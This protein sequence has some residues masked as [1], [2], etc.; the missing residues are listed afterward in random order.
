MRIAGRQANVS[1]VLA[2]PQVD[3]C[4]QLAPMSAAQELLK[5]S[6]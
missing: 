1:A 6:C 4:R 3:F 5:C 2:G